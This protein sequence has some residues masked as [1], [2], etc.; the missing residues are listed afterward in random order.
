MYVFVTVYLALFLHIIIFL[1]IIILHAIQ[2]PNGK[3]VGFPTMRP[4][5]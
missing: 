2:Y 4:W 3:S 5:V 1:I